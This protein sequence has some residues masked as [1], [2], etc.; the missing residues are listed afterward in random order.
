MNM[1]GNWGSTLRK[2]SLSLVLSMLLPTF[3][4]SNSVMAAEQI[5]A[6]Y[7]ALE[8]SIPISILESYAK[9]GI[10]NADLAG[11]YQYIPAHK[12]QELRNILM[13]P[14]RISPSVA[15]QFL[16]TQQGKF[17]LQR[18]TELIK[19]SSHPKESEF[20][21][22]RTALIAAAA[23]PEGLNLLNLLRKY[24]QKSIS[25]DV[26]SGMQIADELEKMISETEKA[27]STIIQA[28]HLEAA[29]IS[30]ENLSQLSELSNQP[31]LL[32]QKQ[33]LQLFDSIRN[34]HL[35]TD[36]YIPNTL[37]PAPVIVISHGL[38]LDSSN[39]RYLAN[40]LAKNGFAV[41]IPNH[42]GSDAKQL[43]SLIKRNSNQ[44]AHPNEFKDRPLDIKYIL[45]QLG[46]DSR[47][48]H[49][50]NLQ[51]VGVFGQSL[52]GYTALALVGAKINFEQLKQDCHAEKVRNTW[53]MSLLLQCR[54]LEL[55]NQSGKEDNLQDQ[56]IKAAIAVN[57]ITSSIFGQAGLSQIHTP[58]MIIGSSEDTVAPAL[59]EQ[60]LPFSWITYP[61]KYLVM[62]LGATHFSTI[63][64]SNPGSTQIA[65]STDMVGDVFQAQHY[66]NALSLPFFQTY[67]AKKPEYLPYLNA[68]YAQSI[69]SQSLGLNLVQSLDHLKLAPALD[70]HS[71]ETNPV[72]K[73]FPIP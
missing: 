9:H 68:A 14:L 35:S 23:E 51:Q 37:Q 60:I 61:Q 64:N 25:I 67:V 57:P 45:D 6:S 19:T 56:R 8:I 66:M 3:G 16:D 32:T 71:P 13:Q 69:S 42:P 55:P 26:A 33:T 4:I 27:I 36:I 2:N 38:G 18:L 40:Y 29:T 59:Y 63:G 17:I 70:D 10:I 44:V 62:L 73:N 31:N 5:H 54:A 47:F 43:Q 7:S 30:L 72:K 22:L 11:Y 65:L 53:N 20:Q 46:S 39:F 52:G 28:S 21:A 12:L 15:S 1:F 34:R 58:V 48:Q 41:V 24:P 49:R 50:L